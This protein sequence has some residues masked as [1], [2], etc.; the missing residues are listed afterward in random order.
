MCTARVCAATC[1][2]GA[3]TAQALRT[4]TRLVHQVVAAARVVEAGAALVDEEEVPLGPVDVG[5]KGL[6]RD[7]P[8]QQRQR[9]PARECDGEAAALLH[10][11]VVAHDD[12]VCELLRHLLLVLARQHRRVKHHRARAVG[13]P[14]SPPAGRPRSPPK[15]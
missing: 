10:R 15:P 13:R 9:P 14:R 3:V 12:K 7:A 6:L 4:G 5:D 1:R 11:L 8:R 2:R